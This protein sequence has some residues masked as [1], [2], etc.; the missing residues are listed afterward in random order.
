MGVQM[1]KLFI[2]A[3]LA[4]IATFGV[5]TVSATVECTICEF[6][7]EYAEK[8]ATSNSTEAEV[9]KLLDDGCNDLGLWVLPVPLWSTP[10]F[11]TSSL[12]L[13]LINLHKPSVMKSLFARTPPELS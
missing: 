3:I 2:L 6:V 5:T 8:F 13:L 7:C 11:L 12:I 10:I 9:E 1:N 4:C